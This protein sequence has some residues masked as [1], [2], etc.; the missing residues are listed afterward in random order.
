MKVLHVSLTPLAGSPIRIVKALNAYTEVEA[1]LINFSRDAYG[2][3]TFPEDLVWQES[4]DEARQLVAQADIVHF[5]HWFEF[6]SEANPFAFDFR[7]AMK[8]GAQSLMHWHSSPLFVAR[9][10]GCPTRDVLDADMPQMVVAQY[11]EPYYPRARPVPLIV[12]DAG[13]ESSGAEA[14]SE[15]PSVF[16]SPS[17]SAS[18][19]AERWEAKG[20]P[21]VLR[22]LERLDRRG[23]V[24]PVVVQDVPF[25][26]CRALRGAADIVIDD[27]VTG[28]FHTTSL[29]ALAQGKATIAYLDSRTQLV[30]SELTQST[31]LPI[32]NVH[33]DHLEKVLTKLCRDRQ[34]VNDL[35]R[36]SKEWMQ[37]FHSD[38]RMVHHYL[39][40]YEELS[41]TG[42]LHNPRYDSHA[43][44]KLF[45]YRDVPDIIWQAKRKSLYSGMLGHTLNRTLRRLRHGPL[46][47]ADSERIDDPEFRGTR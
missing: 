43:N 26:E 32:V 29:E 19:H 4:A 31:D 24:R 28:A 12:G 35:G 18:A 38:E 1:R 42:R 20:K 13:P 15:R 30:L 2:R 37:T 17:N 9:H 7:A 14:S 36:L 41:S 27:V 5:H 46:V 16:F 40:G 3:R 33:L 39:R 44:A 47:S 25:E 6:D 11:H 45:L 34:L 21:E 23:L 8:A 10:A 22:I